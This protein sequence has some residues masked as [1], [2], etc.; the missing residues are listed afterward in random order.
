[1]TVVKIVKDH[2]NINAKNVVQPVIQNVSVR[3]IA[4]FVKE[5]YDT[6][7]LSMIVIIN[8]LHIGKEEFHNVLNLCVK[9]AGIVS[10]VT[11]KVPVINL[12]KNVVFPVIE[13]VDVNVPN[14]ERKLRKVD[15]NAMIQIMFYKRKITIR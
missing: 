12:V 6:M 7:T 4:H 2:V 3:L 15:V 5:N 13:A 14:V 9:I 11:V 10:V 8:V 1:M